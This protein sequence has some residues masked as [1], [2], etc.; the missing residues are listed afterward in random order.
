M[1]LYFVR[2]GES[3]GNQA[4]RHQKPD[5]PLS[6]AGRKQAQVLAER[7]KHLPVEV[8]LSSSYVR[9]Q[10]T[11]KIIAAAT[12]LHVEVAEFV[13]EFKRPSEVEGKGIHDPDVQRVKALV[14]EHFG[15][16][17]WRYSD[18]ENF[19]DLQRRITQFW[20]EVSQ[21]PEKHILVVSHGGIIKYI[22]AVMLFGHALT[23]D[24]ARMFFDGIPMAS[25]GLTIC[26]RRDDQTWKL[27]TL[28]DHAHLG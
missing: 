8:I 28:N 27:V 22:V 9:A 19:F 20:L 25:T 3:E 18:E 17:G 16:E 4:A 10:E 14:R 6:E 12:N 21:R 23:P 13:R 26:E 24:L 7:V 5:T 15:D 2:H 1:R 11:A